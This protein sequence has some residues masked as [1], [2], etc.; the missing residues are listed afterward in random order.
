MRQSR[1]TKS[2]SQRVAWSQMCSRTYSVGTSYK[3]IEY[4]VRDKASTNLNITMLKHQQPF[5]LPRCDPIHLVSLSP[6]DFRGRVKDALCR[7]PVTDCPWPSGEC[8]RAQIITYDAFFHE[9][10]RL[11]HHFLSQITAKLSKWLVANIRQPSGDMAYW[12][13]DD[14]F[15]MLRRSEITTYGKEVR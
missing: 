6:G 14:K 3:K 9:L 10:H 7:W 13:G 12:N 2:G 1:T 8:S 5:F 11:I 15:S 4:D